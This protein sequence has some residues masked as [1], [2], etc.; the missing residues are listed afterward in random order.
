MISPFFNP[1]CKFI[2]IFFIK[3][4]LSLILTQSFSIPHYNLKIVIYSQLFTFLFSFPFLIRLIVGLIRKIILLRLIIFINFVVGRVFVI[5]LSK[6]WSH[7]GLLFLLI[8]GTWWRTWSWRWWFLNNDRFLLLQNWIHSLIIK[9]ISVFHIITSSRRTS[10]LI[11][12][13]LCLLPR[14]LR[15]LWIW[16][17]WILGVLILLEMTWWIVY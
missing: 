14:N 9:L 10:L 4:N 7:F 13:K 1:I 6:E 5:V 3:V 11:L 12:T 15:I 2:S 16:I 17:W 8:W